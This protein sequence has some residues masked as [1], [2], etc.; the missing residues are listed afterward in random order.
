MKTGPPEVKRRIRRKRQDR[1][2]GSADRERIDL[3]LPPKVEVRSQAGAVSGGGVRGA[4]AVRGVVVVVR[5]DVQIEEKAKAVT[6]LSYL[7]MT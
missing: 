3:G 4:D 5:K 7:S 6:D 2:D 1:I